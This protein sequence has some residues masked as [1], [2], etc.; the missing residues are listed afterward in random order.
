MPQ[1]EA[2]DTL[3]ATIRRTFD[4]DYEPLQVDD[5]TLQVLTIHN[6]QAHLDNLLHTR[7]I[8]A[9]RSRI[10]RSGPKS[11]PVLLCSAACCANMSRREKPSSNWARVAAF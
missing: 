2:L 5:D 4:V 11:G 7:A 10:C 3:L 1:T 8:R 6:M 9:T